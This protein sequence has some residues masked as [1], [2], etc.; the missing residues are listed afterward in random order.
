MDKRE[1]PSGGDYSSAA[2]TLEMLKR[3]LAVAEIVAKSMSSPP[4]TL[5]KS[6]E[7]TRQG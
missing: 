6:D 7:K 1:A 3:V 4:P 2:T 5:P